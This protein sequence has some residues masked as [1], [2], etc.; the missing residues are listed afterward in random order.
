MNDH[1]ISIKIFS[2]L[3][4][5]GFF[6]QACGSS[7]Q[8]AAMVQVFQHYQSA[9][10]AE[11]PQQLLALISRDSRAFL[12]KHLELIKGDNRE[13]TEN[14]VL[15]SKFPVLDVN[16]IARGLNHYQEGQM[17]T[18][19]EQAFLDFDL[20]HLIQLEKEAIAGFNFRE[21]LLINDERARLKFSKPLEDGTNMVAELEFV[22]EDDKWKLNLL[23]RLN[24]LEN[25]SRI[26]L[27]YA[28][29]NVWDYVAE[30]LDKY[31]PE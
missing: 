29:Q 16:M 24:V 21:K 15:E 17:E 27:K 25:N 5:A 19:S 11:E 18:V 14:Y 8:E 30:K 26:T 1:I 3:L 20:G 9:V 10:E 28:D 31:Y 6:L 4:L 12:L 13:V 7:E 23:D 22:K 2:F